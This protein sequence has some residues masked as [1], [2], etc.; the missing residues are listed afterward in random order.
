MGGTEHRSEARPNVFL[1]ATL[2]AGASSIPV[3]IRNLSTRGALVE[4][5]SL[6]EAGT[7]VRVVRGE[8]HASGEVAWRN[9]AFGGVCFAD[10]IEVERWIRRAGHRGQMRVDA[11]VAALR[12]S[13]EIP[14][15]LRQ[16]E[17][18]QSLATISAALDQLCENLVA[19]PHLWTE[20]G[21]ELIRLDSIAQA[22]RRHATGSA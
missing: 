12:G 2:I 10:T 1:S 5:S 16:G 20:L 11:M 19:A 3:R 22:L 4:C 14:P 17:D 8:L 7:P 6:P 18:G 21:E 13:A 9:S 15:E